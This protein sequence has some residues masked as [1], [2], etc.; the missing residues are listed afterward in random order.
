MSTQSCNL[1]LYLSFHLWSGVVTD[2]FFCATRSVG[3]NTRP[4]VVIYPLGLV[5]KNCYIYTV[6]LIKAK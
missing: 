3:D 2:Q 5:N 6:E 1:Q 4:K